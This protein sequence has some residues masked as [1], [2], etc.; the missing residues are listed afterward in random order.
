MIEEISGSATFVW[1]PNYELERVTVRFIK[2]IEM[3]HLC[4]ETNTFVLACP[5][6]RRVLSTIS[7]ELVWNLMYLH[8]TPLPFGQITFLSYY[9]DGDFLLEA[10]TDRFKP[11]LV[12]QAFTS[13]G[14]KEPNLID[15]ILSVSEKDEFKLKLQYGY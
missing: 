13:F 6:A 2:E 10:G 12:E 3:M 15:N 1:D 5:K 14:Y 11:H 9:S 8:D 4:T 7:D